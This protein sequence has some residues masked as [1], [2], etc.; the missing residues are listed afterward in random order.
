MTGGWFDVDKEGLAAI[1]QRRGMAFVP[2]ELL[3][4]AWDEAG[5]TRVDVRLMPWAGK[6]MACG[7]RVQDNSPDG[8]R[9]LADAWTLFAA[10]YKK[11]NAEQRGRFNLGEKL[12]LACC[13]WAEIRSTTG[14]VRFDDKGKHHL[15]KTLDA[16]T[17]FQANVRMTREQC[18]E[19]LE[20]LRTVLAPPGIVTTVNGE[21][22]PV[23]EPVHTFRA[24]L[25]TEVAD[26]EGV[27]RRLRRMADVRLFDPLPGEE[28][29]LYEM[30]IPVQA[31]GDRWHVDVGQ[32]VPLTL[33][34]DAVPP[35]YLA[36]LR[37]EVVNAM[38]DRLTEEDV[39]EPWVREATSHK[40]ASAEAVERS[41]DL[42]FGKDRVMIDPSDL[43]ANRRA[44]AA[45]YRVVHPSQL[46]RGEREHL[47][48][49]EREQGRKVV[50]PAGRVF[51][52]HGGSISTTC[53]PV[54]RAQWNDA[55]HRVA[56]LTTAIA[57][58]VLDYDVHVHL[59]HDNDG[60]YAAT[61]SRG[62]VTYNVARLRSTWWDRNDAEGWDKVVRLVLHELA[63]HLCSNHLDDA[64]HRACCLLGARLARA[65]ARGAIT[66]SEFGYTME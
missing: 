7:L 22:L 54:P 36:R 34:R 39:A 37:A 48:R 58:H 35:A 53:K 41:L 60:G 26:D 57:R 46:T 49:I 33:E 17:V 1:M 9:D 28:P 21:V 65:V 51:P 16:G 61:Y 10:S 38:H 29:T 11:G 14:G 64:Y 30:G 25:Q 31:L 12:V 20:V 15:R 50:R 42:R 32:C 23:R 55:Y 6:R 5:V 44:Q 24:Q 66:P 3:Q 47:K 18:T 8:F 62:R 13:R 63:H 43:E 56:G 59:V 4:N 27:L 2:L 45:G 40:Q 19:A 52:T